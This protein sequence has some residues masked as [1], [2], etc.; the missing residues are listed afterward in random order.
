MDPTYTVCF[1]GMLISDMGFVLSSI[2]INAYVST[3]YDSSRVGVEQSK[4][5]AADLSTLTMTM[6]LLIG[7]F[8]GFICDKMK[9]FPLLLLGYGIRAGGL[10]MM[11]L[12][13]KLRFFLFISTLCLNVGTAVE[14][15]L[16]R[17]VYYH[18]FFIL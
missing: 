9:F 10:I 5:L 12:V 13:S 14:G 6:G 18:N 3:F 7:L 4:N 16:V 8:A 1:I 17:L 11:P 15:V 2:Y